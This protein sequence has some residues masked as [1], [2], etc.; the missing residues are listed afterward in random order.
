MAPDLRHMRVHLRFH[1]LLPEQARNRRGGTI[2]I[3]GETLRDMRGGV[4]QIN[5]QPR[6]RIVTLS[7]TDERPSLWFGCGR[8]AAQGRT[9][10]LATS[11]CRRPTVGEQSGSF[12]FLY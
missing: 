12:A 5:Q 4:Q 9:G 2:V 3:S 10:F 11:P 8:Q 1:F 6:P 7:A